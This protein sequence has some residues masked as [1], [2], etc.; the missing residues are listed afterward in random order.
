MRPY[1]LAIPLTIVVCLFGAAS[2]RADGIFSPNVGAAV[3]GDAESSPPSW[4]ISLA[5]MAGGVFGF[6]FDFSRTTDLL[7]G[8]PVEALTGSS[9]TT[10]MGNLIV[11]V[12]AGMIR[13]Y[14]TGGVGLIRSSLEAS[15]GGVTVGVSLTDL[16]MNVGGGIMGFFSDHLGAR[17]DVRYFRTLTAGDFGF[18]VGEIFDL[19]ELDMWR[20]SVGLAVRF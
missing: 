6:E 4:G 18:D 15:G 19:G 8:G 10:A 14:V 17:V 11:G 5:G 20:A 3:G 13:P 7:G 9:V 1:R 16:G 2:A 12:P